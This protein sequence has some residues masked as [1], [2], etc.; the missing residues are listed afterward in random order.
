MKLFANSAARPERIEPRFNVPSNADAPLT[1]EQAARL[2]GWITPTYAGRDVTPETAMR[3]STV[4]ACVRLITGISA[5]MPF[6]VYK[7]GPDGREE[8]E[9]HPVN[10]LLNDEPCPGMSAAIFWKYAIT[11]ELLTGDSL[12]WIERDRN[13]TALNLW[14]LNPRATGIMRDQGTGRLIYSTVNW[15]GDLV[16]LDQDDVL[17]VPGEGFD[18]LR[19]KS[20]I[21]WAARQGA[22]IALAADE[23]A[24][25]F[26]ANGA[27]P[28]FALKY[29]K[30]MSDD[31]KK[32]LIDHYLGRHQGLEGS[33]LPLVLTEGGELAEMSMSP[34]DTQLLD[35]RKFQVVDICRAFGVPPILVGDS[36]KSSSWGTGIEQMVLGFVKFAIH[37]MLVK[38]EQEV[39]R[40]LL[41]SKLYRRQ[42]CFA[43]WNL[44]GLLRG[45]SKAQ[46]EWMRALVGGPSSGPGIMSQNEARGVLNLKKDADPQADKLFN[47]TGP[48]ATPGKAPDA[49]AP[50]P[51]PA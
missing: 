4:F 8:Q 11:S 9:S 6:P 50:A 29:P 19:G 28:D 43:E 21:G 20:V 27:R 41:T 31:A 35:T 18:G 7:K 5:A 46:A 10:W 44:D 33:H 37:P 13:G 49:Q 2:S 12:T 38:Y 15:R 51:Q 26:F 25:R 30:K 23:Y 24:G 32:G 36:E 22:G 1:W 48:A 40:K 45:D 14:P 39:N 17:H 47:P 42:D 34:N 16:N 3:I